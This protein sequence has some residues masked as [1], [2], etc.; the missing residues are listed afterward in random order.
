[1]K[2]LIIIKGNLFF[3][4]YSLMIII[5]LLLLASSFTACSPQRRLQR[6]VARHP[7]LRMADTLLVTDTLFTATITADMAIPLTHLTDTVVITRDRL[8]ISLVRHL[9]TIHVKGTCKADTIVRELRVPFEKI[10]LV[11][12]EAGWLSK[13][14][15]IILGVIVIAMFY[16]VGTRDTGRGT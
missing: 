13:L 8:E 15:W 2:K 16:K 11:K 3:P 7:E 6:L 12:A 9:D 5:I 10:K 14:P 4:L 1:M